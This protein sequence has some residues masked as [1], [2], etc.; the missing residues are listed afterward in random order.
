MTSAASGTVEAMEKLLSVADTAGLL[1]V[2]KSSVYSWAERGQIPSQKVRGRLMFVP[3]Q[4]QTW[5]DEQHR[6]ATP[7]DGRSRGLAV[8]LP[9]HPPEVADA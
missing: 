2:G 4:L 1:G 9:A 8:L 6:P 3:S 7:R 5:L